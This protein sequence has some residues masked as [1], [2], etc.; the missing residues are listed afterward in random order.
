MGTYYKHTKTES[1]NVPYS[2]RCE[3]C[4]QESGMLKAT[5]SA[6]AEVSSNYKKLEEKK[7][8][9]LNEMAHAN[10]VKAVKE[11]YSDAAEKQ[12]YS[13]VFKDQCPHCSK[14]QSWGVGGMKKGIFGTPIGLVICGIIFG[15]GGYFVIEMEN[16]LMISMIIA[17]A[18]LVLAAGNLLW[19]VF[20]IERKKKLTSSANQKNL[21]V[22]EWGVVQGILKEQ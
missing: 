18:F 13:T 17:G 2:F 11:A 9:K 5:I 12:I 19:S 4:M 10:L 21:P 3:Q 7:Q 14:P 6:E 16:K 15:V 20:K 1:I 22:I 8:Q